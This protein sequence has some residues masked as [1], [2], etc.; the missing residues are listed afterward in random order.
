[1]EKAKL[2]PVIHSFLYKIPFVSAAYVRSLQNT[3]CF[4]RLGSF[5]YK[6]PFV[7]AA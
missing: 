5:L 2:N 4:S 1:M 6:I 3:V 7:S